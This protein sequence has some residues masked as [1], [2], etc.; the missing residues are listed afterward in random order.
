M[1]E[2]GEW[3]GIR[4]LAGGKYSEGPKEIYLGRGDLKSMK[5]IYTLQIYTLQNISEMK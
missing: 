1:K 3:E 5:E 4:F 2:N